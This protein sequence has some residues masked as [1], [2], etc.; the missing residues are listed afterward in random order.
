MKGRA[1]VDRLLVASCQGSHPAVENNIIAKPFLMMI[2]ILLLWPCPL[3]Y[4]HSALLMRQQM[5]DAY[6]ICEST[7]FFVYR[8]IFSVLFCLFFIFFVHSFKCFLCLEHIFHFYYFL[9]SIYVYFLFFFF[10]FFL[11]SIINTFC[12]FSF[13]VILSSTAI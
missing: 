3:I 1:G 13:F 12:T 6:I 7:V 9:F 4:K 10:L 8:I 11:Y 5:D 2:A